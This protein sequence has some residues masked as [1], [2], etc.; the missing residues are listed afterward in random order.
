MRTSNVS[1]SS[2]FKSPMTTTLQM[3]FM[4]ASILALFLLPVLNHFNFLS[5]MIHTTTD[6]EERKT[7][8]DRLDALRMSSA[9]ILVAVLLI[10]ST[11][12]LL[13]IY[14]HTHLLALLYILA[15]VFLSVSMIIVLTDTV[16]STYV[17]KS[18]PM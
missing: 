8:Y 13:L 1:L 18:T 5:S 14:P 16:R 11:I 15:S 10:V 7:L 6:S 3:T 9:S 2:S 17:L 12:P 4:F